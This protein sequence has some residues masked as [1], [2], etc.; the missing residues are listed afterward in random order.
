MLSFSISPSKCLMNNPEI[1]IKLIIFYVVNICSAYP[2]IICV[3]T[4]PFTLMLYRQWFPAL[5]VVFLHQPLPEPHSMPDIY[6]RLNYT[7]NDKFAP[8]TFM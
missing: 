1:S 4:A 3:F 7:T 5:H 8:L 6:M 2:V